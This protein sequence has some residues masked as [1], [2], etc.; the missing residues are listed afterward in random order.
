MESTNYNALTW[1]LMPPYMDAETKGAAVRWLKQLFSAMSYENGD[2]LYDG[3]IN[4]YYDDGLKQA[5]V[6]LQKFMGFNDSTDLDGFFGPN[7]RKRFQEL[8]YIDL[9]CIPGESR[10]VTYYAAPDFTILLEWVPGV[11]TDPRDKAEE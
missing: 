3:P 7:T 10:D 2:K 8:F 4:E 6:Q 5:V 1:R 9:N 11:T